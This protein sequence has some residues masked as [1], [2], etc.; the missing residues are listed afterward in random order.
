MQIREQPD[1][2][3]VPSQATHR[4]DGHIT[5]LQNGLAV[6]DMFQVDHQTVTVAEVARHLGIHKST[7]SRIAATLVSA[8]FLRPAS[9]KSGFQLSGKLTRLGNIAA[10]DTH[11]TTV[12]MPFL[13]SLVDEV[14]ETC[15][16]G[17]LEGREAVTVALVDGSYSVRLHSFVGKR[18]PAHWTAMGKVLLSSL[19]ESTLD[20]LYPF[21]ELPGATSKTIVSKSNLLAQ[22]EMIRKHGFAIDDEELEVGLRCVAAPVRDHDGQVVASLTVAGS[23]S[24]IQTSKMDLYAR[25]VISHADLISRELGSPMELT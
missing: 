23:S 24:R 25:K 10:A 11:L 1:P 6:F 17:V 9:G 5:A 18:S 15:H 16:L 12:S 4:T 13:R 2:V 14:G 7:A 20:M 3:T 21:E 22:L 8:G 19:T